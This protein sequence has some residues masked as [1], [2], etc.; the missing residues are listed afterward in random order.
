HPDVDMG[1]KQKWIGQMPWL[2]EHRNGGAR[3]AVLVKRDDADD[4]LG[5]LVV[6][7]LEKDVVTTAMV[8][9]KRIRVKVV[10]GIGTDVPARAA[11]F[12]PLAVLA[13]EHR[14]SPADSTE[15]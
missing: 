3:L 4:A 5:G 2:F 9:R 6:E 12:A 11:E 14:S 10:A 8:E 15:G 7:I 1:L 13:V